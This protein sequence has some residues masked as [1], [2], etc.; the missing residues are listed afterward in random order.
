MLTFKGPHVSLAQG[1]KARAPSQK[2]QP[3]QNQRRGRGHRFRRHELPPGFS[4]PW[5]SAPASAMKN[6]EPP[7][8]WAKVPDVKIELDETPVGTYLE[9]EGPAASDRSCRNHARVQSQGLSDG[10]LRLPLPGRMP[11]QRPQTR[12]Y[13][14]S[15]NKKIYVNEHSFLDKDFNSVYLLSWSFLCGHERI[16]NSENPF[17]VG[18]VGIDR[19]RDV[20]CGQTRRR[21]RANRQRRKNPYRPRVD[22]DFASTRG[23]ATVA[24]GFKV[25]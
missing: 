2:S 15:A 4:A 19:W 23:R 10:N 21:R 3:L 11:A 1:A 7:M 13:A 17:R 8:R 18:Q 22:Q 25:Q 24:A 5:D 12:Q 20:S 9:L 14:V 16:R 6:S